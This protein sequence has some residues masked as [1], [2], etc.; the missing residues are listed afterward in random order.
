MLYHKC[1]VLYNVCYIIV[2]YVTHRDVCCGSLL[3]GAV[4]PRTCSGTHAIRS[5]VDYDRPVWLLSL[6]NTALYVIKLYR[7]I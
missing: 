1:V 4:L 3:F 2:V 7:I 6:Y 5:T